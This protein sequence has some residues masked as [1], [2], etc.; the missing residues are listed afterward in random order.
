MDQ[1]KRRLRPRTWRGWT[2]YGLVVLILVGVL[3]DASERSPG[4]PPAPSSA[5]EAAI[6]DSPEIQAALRE[7]LRDE[8]ARLRQE[9][10]QLRRERAQERRERARARRLRAARRQRARERERLAREAEEATLAQESAPAESCHP[11]YDP[12]LDPSATDY[13]C[14]GGSGNG[15]EYTG[16]VTVKGPDDYG[17]D[18][19]DDGLGCEP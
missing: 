10:A 14:S 8:R 15:P 12:C 18:S 16:T 11:S 6:V 19:D 4:A 3:A 7:K 17:L 1:W 2:L 13:D 9:R 5:H